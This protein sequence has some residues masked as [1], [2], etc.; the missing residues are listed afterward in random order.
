[1]LSRLCS[2]AWTS[3][4]LSCSARTVPTSHVSSSWGPSTLPS[5]QHR[6]TR[7]GTQEATQLGTGWWQGR[8]GLGQSNTREQSLGKCL[9]YKVYPSG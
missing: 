5:A 4:M 7:K 6:H 9:S 3:C 1:M 2:L 8:A